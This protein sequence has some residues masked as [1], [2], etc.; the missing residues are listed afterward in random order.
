MAPPRPRHRPNLSR[1]WIVL[2]DGGAARVLAV[3][4]AHTSLD[5]LREMHAAD[6][7]RKTHDLVTDR[8]GRSHESASP[9]RHGIEAKTDP[10]AQAKENFVGEVAE[11]LVREYRAGAFDEL[12]L[13]VTPAQA[14]N[15][16]DG[17]DAATAAVV[18]ATLTKDLVK[19]PNAAVW[20]RLI[21][22]GLMPP[23]ATPP[24]A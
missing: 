9:T 13:A 12:I 24:R 4:E 22:E 11:M 8:A 21:A 16:K 14:Q 15:L 20:D 1:R 10:H 7:H 3:S 18:R 19:E 6:V 2:V 23:R 17:L 5:T